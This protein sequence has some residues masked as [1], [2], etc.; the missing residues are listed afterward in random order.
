MIKLKDVTCQF[1]NGHTIFDKLNLT[2]KKGEFV[3]VMGDNGAGKSTLM[4]VITGS[5]PITSGSIMINDEDVTKLNEH[6]RTKKIAKVFQDPKIS[7]CGI[8]T[9]RENLALALNKGQHRSL[10]KGVSK[11]NDDL[12]KESLAELDMGLEHELDKKAN[13]LS[14]GMRQAL[15]LI[16]AKL[17]NPDL[18][19]LDEHTAA[20]DPQ[21]SK[22]VMNMTDRIVR[23]NSLT[24]IMITHSIPFANANGDRLI[25]MRNG[26]IVLDVSGKEKKDMTQADFV[27]LFEA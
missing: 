27:N 5:L 8:M 20:L 24:S 17:S 2:I 21:A 10:K 14:G 13:E 3:I 18:L 25:F 12:L 11:L 23:N 7:T 19:L 9:V 16:M 26:K 4:N 15:S 1:S 6:R 22:L